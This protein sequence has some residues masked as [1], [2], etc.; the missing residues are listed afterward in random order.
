MIETQKN[1]YTPSPHVLGWHAGLWNGIGGI[2][3]VVSRDQPASYPESSITSLIH[4][5]A[6]LPACLNRVRTLA[7]VDQLCGSLGPAFGNTGA[8]YQSALANFWGGWAFLVGSILQWYE[9][10][11]KNPVEEQ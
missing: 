2:G 3:F 6:H 5:P 9:S 1:W 7:D 4:I 8:Q 10:L 11:D